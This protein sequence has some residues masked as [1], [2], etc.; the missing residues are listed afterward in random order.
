MT[1]TSA[2]PYSSAFIST[3]AYS[4]RAPSVLRAISFSFLPSTATAHFEIVR[5]THWNIRTL[6]RSRQLLPAVR[7]RLFQLRPDRLQQ[8][9]VAGGVADQG[10]HVPARRERLQPHHADDAPLFAAMDLDAPVVAG[11]MASISWISS[12][13]VTSFSIAS[14]IVSLSASAR[15]TSSHNVTSFLI[16]S[17]PAASC[18]LSF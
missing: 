13:G 4:R 7:L 6:C 2:P 9:G 17:L 1:P 16:V 8:F 18:S 15:S 5:S 12:S 3:A 10:R 11:C 14:S